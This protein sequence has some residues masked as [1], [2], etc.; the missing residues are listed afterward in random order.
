MNIEGILPIISGMVP[1]PVKDFLAR[2]GLELKDIP[3]LT[4]QLKQG[5]LKYGKG[6]LTN[7]TKAFE[8]ALVNGIEAL[9][10]E[11]QAPVRLSIRTVTLEGGTKVPVCVIEVMK[12]ITLPCAEGEAPKT[13]IERNDVKGFPFHQII[14]MVPDKI[15]VEKNESRR[16]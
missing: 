3:E 9:E 8:P 1:K 12:E 11:H 6:V 10:E 13:H 15:E 14:S 2:I 4:R 16:L 7:L 5:D